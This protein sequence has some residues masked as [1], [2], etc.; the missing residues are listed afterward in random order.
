MFRFVISLRCE[1]RIEF[2]FHTV[3]EI[4]CESEMCEMRDVLVDRM[5]LWGLGDPP[6]PDPT[7][8]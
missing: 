3:C 6:T 1:T 5:N 4:H 2:R 8:V 7:H